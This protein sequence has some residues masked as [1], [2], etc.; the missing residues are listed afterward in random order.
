MTLNQMKKIIF[1]TVFLAAAVANA[2]YKYPESKTVQASD[3][4]FGITVYDPY[5]WHIIPYPKTKFVFRTI[6]ITN[7][8]I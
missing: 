6:K 3:T 5:R 4:Y 7:K 1:I 2:Q 8:I